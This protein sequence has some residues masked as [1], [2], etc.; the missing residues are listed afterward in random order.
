MFRPLALALFVAALVPLAGCGPKVQDVAG[1]VALDGKSVPDASV[2]FVSSTGNSFNGNTDAS[3]NFAIP[4]VP[5]GEYKVVVAKYPKRAGTAPT[6][7]AKMDKAYLDSMTKGT[8]KSKSGQM[9]PMPGK[10]GKMMMP[11]GGPSGSGA[12][13]EL[14]EQYASVEKTPLTAKVPAEGG[15][16]LQLK[17]K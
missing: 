3:G 7:D 6:E 16:Q 14:P 8:D 15:V 12:K 5:A 9:M 4:A 10:G 1:S 2:S 13:S 17:S 11:G